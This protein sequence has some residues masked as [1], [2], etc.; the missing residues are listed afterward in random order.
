MEGKYDEDI[1]PVM[2]TLPRNRSQQPTGSRPRRDKK[3]MAPD[4]KFMED[5]GHL[6]DVKDGAGRLGLGR[7]LLVVAEFLGVE[8]SMTYEQLYLIPILQSLGMPLSLASLVGLVSGPVGAVLVPV[9]GWLS[10][11]GSNP[12]RRK[13]LGVVFSTG[14]L[15][16]GLMLVLLASYVYLHSHEARSGA[17]NNSSMVHSSHVA[18]LKR[19]SE[20]YEDPRARAT[21]NSSAVRSSH[22][23]LS[24]RSSDG[25]DNHGARGSDSSPMAQ[26]LATSLLERSTDGLNTHRAEA[27]GHSSLFQNSNGA[28]RKRST[29]SHDNHWAM[30][31]DNSSKVQNDQTAR[32]K[33]SPESYNNRINFPTVAAEID[34]GQQPR[35]VETGEPEH[36]SREKDAVPE[37]GKTNA[38]K[39]LS[40]NNS[41]SPESHTVQNLETET[42]ANDS[43]QA[44]TAERLITALNLLHLEGVKTSSN[45]KHNT[46]YA[47]DEGKP[48]PYAMKGAHHNEINSTVRGRASFL[49]D[50]ERHTT[51]SPEPNGTQGW[52]T[53][54]K[55]SGSATSTP[56]E[57]S[58]IS[59]P[60]E[61]SDISTPGE[62][63]DIST[64]GEAS[65]ISAPDEGSDISTPDE[66]SDIF[67]PDE[68]SDM[69]TP[70]EASEKSAPGQSSDISTPG[71]SSDIS[72]PGQSSDISTQS[73]A[74]ST[75]DNPD[76]GVP[77]TA[78]LAMFGFIV[79]E[80]GY[81]QTSSVVRAW[82]LTCS[83]H[84]EHTSLLVLGLV[85]AG[86]GMIVTSALGRVDFPSLCNR[87][88]DGNAGLILQTTI[89]GAVTVV[90]I[91][92]GMLSTLLTGHSLL[93]SDDN[94]I[95]ANADTN[96]AAGENESSDESPSHKCRSKAHGENFD[97]GTQTPTVPVLQ[98]KLGT[99]SENSSSSG[100]ASSDN[101]M[102]ESSGA[103]S[104]G[105]NRA[106]RCKQNTARL[107]VD[108]ATKTSQRNPFGPLG[109]CFPDPAARLFCC[110]LFFICVGMFFTTGAHDMFAY[111]ISDY[112]GKAVYGGDPR[113]EAG[114]NQLHSYMAGVRN[115]AWGMLTYSVSYLLINLVHTRLLAILG[116]KVEFVLVQLLLASCFVVQAL[117]ARLEVF[118]VLS[119]VAGLHRACLYVVT[120]AAA[121]DVI[122]AQARHG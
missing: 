118:F 121:N 15:L 60:G 4:G 18:F 115:T 71:Q 2:H 78:G 63:S 21:D 104:V 17:A 76:T 28:L 40:Q 109:G 38:R 23:A 117:T 13:L 103:Y 30:Q 50:T 37:A 74:V 3:L 101:G 67:T 54:A 91:L 44:S 9:F 107:A 119:V 1:W 105:T 98:K 84:T 110:K 31:T 86:L 46:T 108:S 79:Y 99:F 113:A 12:N 69:S 11:R 10:D 5:Q 14:L 7:K 66:A 81:D 59:T 88:K 33:R 49:V 34:H 55:S 100:F 27:A 52:T 102:P 87:Q 20:S 83:P 47:N 36:E 112:V 22:T 19:S 122:R 64:P 6:K 73:E 114:S 65:D 35:W 111:M 77:F 8:S 56:G 96:P 42:N 45:P 24:N 72:T 116:H 85:M 48:L 43:K 93:R 97:Y 25:Y 58:D 94:G 82:I 32:L 68:G 51:H 80:V 95:H 29:E 26:I 53:S 62:A 61:T 41:F 70:G 57:V 90:L 16:L 89:Q 92:V 106:G 39:V 75:S 120:F